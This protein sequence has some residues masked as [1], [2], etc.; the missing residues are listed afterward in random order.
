MCRRR[1]RPNQVIVLA[2]DGP[3]NRGIQAS[4]QQVRSPVVNTM[5]FTG[6]PDGAVA[7][8]ELARVLTPGGRMVLIDINYPRNG[9]RIGTLLIDRFWKPFGDL[10]RDLPALLSDAGLEVRDDEIGGGAAS[11]GTLP[12]SLVPP[13]PSRDTP[14]R[15]L[16]STVGAIRRPTTETTRSPAAERRPHAE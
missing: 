12:P 16:D 1:P 15:G 4:D 8:A 2:G 11:T 9:N 5:A 3:A 10:I 6:Y 7:S 13:T 14:T